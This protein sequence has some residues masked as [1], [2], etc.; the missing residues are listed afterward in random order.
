MKKSLLIV[1]VAT[2]LA[3]TA[4]NNPVTPSSK[5]S[6]STT[7]SSTTPTSSTPSSVEQETYM[8][9]IVA[10]SG[11][12]L[13]ADKTTAHEGDLITLTYTVSAGYSL[14]SIAMNGSALALNNGT[15]TFTMP[16]HDV[17]IKSSVNVA[18]DVV[19]NG[20]IAVA[21]SKQEDGT[22]AAKNVT[23]T[24]DSTFC[25]QVSANGT[26][27]TLDG[28]EIVDNRKTFAHIENA[29][30]D[31]YLVL[32]GGA[33]YD[34][35][36]DPANPSMPFS[37]QR[38]NTITLPSDASSLS[39]L[40][41]MQGI[42]SDPT[43][44]PSGV[45]SVSFFDSRTSE[46]YLWKK[47][48]KASFA[49]ITLAGD[50]TPS[51]YVYKSM[52]GDAYT[53]VD[54]YRE[55]RSWTDPLPY[56]TTS[57]SAL[58]NS[59][60][61]G[62]VGRN[63]DDSAMSGRYKLVDAIDGYVPFSSEHNTSWGK[64]KYEYL[65]N[66]GAADR[67]TY[68]HD[69]N[70][71]VYAYSH[72]V[73]SLEDALWSS[74]F[75]G[76]AIEDDRT[77]TS[78]KIASSRNAD[79]G[80]TTTIDSYQT[81]TPSTASTAAGSSAYM[82]SDVHVTYKASLT[83]TKAGAPL[84]GTYIEKM[85][86]SAD[87]DFSSGAFKTG[88]EANGSVVKRF[89][90]AYT[91]GAAESGKPSFDTTPYFA[92]SVTAAI[93]GT[94][95]GSA[96]II[97]AGEN[98]NELGYNDFINNPLVITPTPSSALDSWEYIINASSD[99]SKVYY[100]KDHGYWTS[101]SNATGIVSLTI[102]NAF[103]STLATTIDLTLNGGVKPYSFSII[104]S[105]GN[106]DNIQ[107]SSSVFLYAGDIFPCYLSAWP[108]KSVLTGIS[109]SYSTPGLITC[110]LDPM[111]AALTIDS[112]G[113]KAITAET[114]VTVTINDTNYDPDATK[115]STFLVTLEPN[116]SLFGEESS[117]FGDWTLDKDFTA[118]YLGTTLNFG[119][120]VTQET[121]SIH[122]LPEKTRYYKGTVVV[123]GT[124]FSFTYSYD[125][126]TK[127]MTASSITATGGKWASYSNFVMALYCEMSSN[128]I[129]V[130]LEAYA[131]EDASSYTATYYSILG[132]IVHGDDSDDGGYDD[133]S[134]SA[135]A[136]AAA[137]A[138]ATENTYVF[139]TKA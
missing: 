82:K 101:S 16:N 87:F 95:T 37:I 122:G 12:S 49:S 81:Y 3:L 120:T 131:Y 127:A 59:E 121:A 42:K 26:T 58:D 45:N 47:Y 38:S 119:N 63:E 43:S 97:N 4:C 92:S 18:G 36:Y 76:F 134:S 17:T 117:I 106:S 28:S 65:K 71:D 77:A 61:I 85:Y 55:G 93:Q 68:D 80:F 50:T 51:S 132:S 8:V 126:H 99:E 91:Y 118:T 24:N 128:E 57:K 15:A 113:A 84:S 23:V 78:V 70:F 111:S 109:F 94:K 14:V 115:P 102:V 98:I 73:A 104:S 138:A 100:D 21:L 89:N 107:S 48:D 19:L 52:D 13:T 29:A 41:Y 90:Y 56:A 130:A 83:F 22:Y 46:S 53:I 110:T 74:Y 54:T 69:A 34:F 2:L 27:T 66:S 116:S 108:S 72:D 32:K 1:S 67:D 79:E 62:G 112:T 40:L 129:G 20:D 10:N 86:D 39:D 135:S 7:E 105:S 11:V 25:V 31:N 123:D 60:S 35:L 33:V 9:V 75:N 103:D 133:A 6:L 64:Y 5:S 137:L 30:K 96:N 88:G 124:T 125:Q 139:F 114:K 44:Y 136:T